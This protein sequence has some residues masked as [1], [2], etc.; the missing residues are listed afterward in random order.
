MKTFENIS[1]AD[2]MKE[3]RKHREQDRIVQRTYGEECSLKNFKGCHMG[4]AANSAMLAKGVTSPLFRHNNHK[5]QAKFLYGCDSA[6]WFVYLCE[7]IFEGLSVQDSKNWVV[8]SFDAIPEDI[9]VSLLNYIETPIKI[10]ILEKS[11]SYH[12]DKQVLEATDQVI[13]ALKGD[14]DLNAA[15]TA[16]AVHAAAWAAAADDFYKELS[17]FVIEQLKGIVK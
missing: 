12:S 4:C 10:W 15:Y 6:E 7:G 5:E 2:F 16:A 9:D 3:I 1:K 14:G 13:R 17:E 8:D 11:K